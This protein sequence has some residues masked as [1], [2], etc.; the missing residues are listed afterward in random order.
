MSLRLIS[1]IE[2]HVVIVI[3]IAERWR[4]HWYIQTH[5]ML[6]IVHHQHHWSIVS[7]QRRTRVIYQS[8]DVHKP[9]NVRTMIIVVIWRC[10]IVVID[11]SGSII[12]WRELLL[13]LWLLWIVMYSSLRVRLML[14]LYDRKVFLLFD[15]FFEIWCRMYRIRIFLELRRVIVVVI[16]VVFARCFLPSVL[17][18]NLTQH[19]IVIITVVIVQIRQRISEYKWSTLAKCM[20]NNTI[21]V[22]VVFVVSVMIVIASIVAC[23]ELSYWC[24]WF[25]QWRMRIL[26]LFW[27]CQFLCRCSSNVL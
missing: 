27:E 15:W 26:H 2:I 21:L 3:I 10:I 14:F 13:L 20:T 22:I 25:R 17:V 12:H 5:V 7:F 6:L 4:A 1:Q 16:R 11:A 23:D 19:I 8:V 24:V 18:L 9:R